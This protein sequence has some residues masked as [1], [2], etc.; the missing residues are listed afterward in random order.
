M[1]QELSRITLTKIDG[2][3]LVYFL[4]KSQLALID[5][6]GSTCIGVLTIRITKDT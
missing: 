6:N 1:T 5:E 3:K 4:N 2:I